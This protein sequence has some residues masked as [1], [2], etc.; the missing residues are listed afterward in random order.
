MC[1]RIL[2]ISG[3]LAGGLLWGGSAA[4]AESP[5]TPAQAESSRL[6]EAETLYRQGLLQYEK[7]NLDEAI[8]LYTDALKLNPNS[9]KAYSARAGALGKQENYAAAIEDYSAAIAIDEDLAAAYGG[10]GLALSLEGE[11]TAGVDDL[12][13]AAQLF[14]EQEKIEEYFQTLA[15]IESIA[16]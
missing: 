5:A 14:R 12:W 8:A 2:I 6:A 1:S 9:A 11:M 10:R 16:P 4:L 13:T 15:I 3:M 7:G